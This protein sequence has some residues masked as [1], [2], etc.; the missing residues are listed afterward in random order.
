VSVSSLRHPAQ[1][2]RE[3]EGEADPYDQDRGGDYET[4]AHRNTPLTTDETTCVQ[5]TNPA[6]KADARMAEQTKMKR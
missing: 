1:S 2:P 5:P 4:E 6:R 3:V